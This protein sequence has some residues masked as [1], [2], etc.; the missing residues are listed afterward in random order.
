[1]IGCIP[2][3]ALRPRRASE[4]KSFWKGMHWW[5]LPCQ[6]QIVL[7]CH[8]FWD[9]P[10]LMEVMAPWLRALIYPGLGNNTLEVTAVPALRYFGG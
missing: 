7:G 6:R 4:S 8:V 2:D 10:W 3:V 9:A 5:L 1:M